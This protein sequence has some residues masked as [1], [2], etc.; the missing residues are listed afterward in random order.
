MAEQPEKIP[1][2]PIAPRLK[3]GPKKPHIGPHIHAYRAAHKESLGGESDEWWAKV[4]TM[5]VVFEEIYLTGLSKLMI[6]STGI[7]LSRPSERAGSPPVTSSG[8]QK[9]D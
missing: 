5:L 3:N 1:I 2:H 4:C 8:S 9:E 7:V 6:F